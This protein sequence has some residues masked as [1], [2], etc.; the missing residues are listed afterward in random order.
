MPSGG[1]VVITNFITVTNGFMPAN[2]AITA[3]LQANGTN[4]LTLASPTYY[5][6]AS[7]LV[8]SGALPASVTV[9][10]GKFITYVISNNQSGV[11]FHV[12]Y[13]STNMPSVM[14]L[15]ATTIIHINSLGVYDAPYPGGS[16]VAAPVAGSTV[17]LRASVN[18]PFGSYDITSL[19]LAVTGPTPASSFT[20]IL[21]DVNVVANDNYTKIYEYAETT[22]PTTG[23][24]NI[25][26][27]ANEGTEGVNVS[28]ATSITTTFLDLGTPSITTFTAGPNGISTNSYPAN[29]PVS[30]R[31]SDLNRNTN[32]TTID[33]V[34]V[35]VTN[36][37]GD[38]ET[39]TLVETGTNTGIFTNSINV[40]T[41]IVGV[42]DNGVL[43]APV[44]SILTAYY[45]DPTDPTDNT[46]ATA[47]VQP[48]PGVPGVVMSKTIL[49]PAG[50]Q[51][52][53]SN[54]ITFN[55]QAINIGSTTLPNLNL[56]D[57]FP[58]ARL[59]YVS[60][61]LAPNTTNLAAGLL[62]WTNLGALAPGQSTNITVTFLTT[63]TGAATNFATANGVTATN[64]S[65]V[66]FS[67]NKTALNVTK[68]L[69]S[70]TNTPV[71]VG[72]NVV[73]RITVQNTGNTTVNYLPLEDT[74]SAAYYQF[75][76]STI[77][78][79]GAGAGSLIWTNL[80][81]PAAL[82]AGATITNDVTMKVV[83]QGSPANNTATVDFATDS[84]GNPVPTSSSTIGV[85]TA[86]ASINGHVYND[87]NQSGVYTNGDT[88]L[89]NVTL[90]LYTDPNG[91]G[92]PSDGTLVQITT[93]DGNG[94]YE[95]LNLNTGHYVVVE[96]DCPATPAVRRRTTG[97]RS[98]S[99]I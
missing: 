56:N 6:A 19:G 15:P 54:T 76:S 3:T 81:S 72:S 70:P 9:P 45:S 99:P 12:N 29:S 26:A 55:L 37:A 21:T 13:G 22:G 88:G 51:V 27:T 7:N 44:G 98:T 49:S 64:A 92:N 35:V 59:S 93:T 31:V 8:W 33:T 48:L 97:C 41:N 77:T 50:G 24:Y 57:T 34:S 5:P 28:A 25:A 65:S 32:A 23:G 61:R 11:A 17:Y 85:N 38:Y 36:S 87:V 73:F 82:A 84:S 74:F 94:Y 39:L 96:T 1:T 18:D 68:I 20:N 86:S 42:P 80:A 47:T 53:V 66:T 79:N 89:G 4:F 90:Q 16:L 71:A 2:P 83:G 67:I 30:V 69:L 14:V 75:V 52:G 62:A 63:A 95:L 60:A 78:N 91:D 43:Y 46:S 58:I 40:S 10:A